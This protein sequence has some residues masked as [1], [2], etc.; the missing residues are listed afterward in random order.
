MLVDL[1]P[2]HNLSN[3]LNHKDNEVTIAEAIKQEMM[4]EKSY[5]S[6]LIRT[7]N[8][9]LDYIP[10][11]LNLSAVES[12]IYQAFSRET[13]LKTI[14][15]RLHIKEKYDYILIDS[16]PALNLLLINTL[17]CADSVLV[18]VEGSFGAFEGLEQLFEYIKM[19]KQRLNQNLSVEGIVFTK[20]SNTN[21]SKEVR[22]KL[23]NDYGDLLYKAEIPERTE[24][25]K[26]YAE[27]TPLN[28]FKHSKLSVSYNLVSEELIEKVGK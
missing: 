22:E 28:D 23:I 11:S 25:R 15:E 6:N 26:S 1:D 2:Q 27:R 4:F 16:M 14:F 10:T 12:G 8:K 3:Y 19:I 20:V 24:A 21:I 5:L 7:Y 9:D 17:T 18:P 13:I